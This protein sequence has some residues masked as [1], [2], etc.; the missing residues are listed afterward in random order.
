LMSG[1][2]ISGKHFFLQA[3]ASLIEAQ[4]SLILNLLACRNRS[5]LAWSNH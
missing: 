4:V 1:F 2:S 5:L 3:E